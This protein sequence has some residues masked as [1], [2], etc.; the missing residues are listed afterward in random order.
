MQMPI[1]FAQFP[2]CDSRELGARASENN[3]RIQPNMDDSHRSIEFLFMSY[4]SFVLVSSLVR[5]GPTGFTGFYPV[6]GHFF[7]H[8]QIDSTFNDDANPALYPVLP[9]LESV[10]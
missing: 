1:E 5:V 2:Q 6:V 3:Q 4:R 9:S 8:C 10:T 7:A